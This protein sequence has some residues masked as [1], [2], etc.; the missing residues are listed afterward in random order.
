M[1]Y[2]EKLKAHKKYIAKYK[3]LYADIPARHREKAHDLIEKLAD[4][5]VVIDEC[6]EHLMMEGHV[7]TMC[8]GKYNI[9]RE[10]PYSK[11]LDRATR[12]H[13][14]ISGKLADMLP[15]QKTETT[16]KAGEALAAFIA[17]GKPK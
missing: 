12:T 14:A 6:N 15:D 9:D 13:M 3:K 1:E 17:G 10:N 11:V 8:Q 7:V 5:Q 2:E 16:A 4:Q